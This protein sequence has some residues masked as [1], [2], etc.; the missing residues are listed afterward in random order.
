MVYPIAEP[1]AADFASLRVPDITNKLDGLNEMSEMVSLR[2]Q[3]MM[4]R[5]SKFIG[6]LSNIMKKIGTTMETTT[7]NMK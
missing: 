1:V 7:Q 3:M 4:D 2:L 6:T 5:R